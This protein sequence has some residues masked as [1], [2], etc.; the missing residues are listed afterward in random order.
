M[1]MTPPP[2]TISARQATVMFADI[3]DTTALG[4]A[5]TRGDRY[6]Q[7]LLRRLEAIVYAWRRDRRVRRTASKAAFGLTLTAGAVRARPS[8]RRWRCATRSRCNVDRALDRRS[9]SAS[10]S[11]RARSRR[12]R[13]G[14]RATTGPASWAGGTP[15]SALEDR[16]AAGLRRP[17]DLGRD[18]ERAFA[19]RPVEV[20]GAR[21]RARKHL[22]RSGRSRPASASAAASGAWRPSCS[23]T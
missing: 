10:A 15:A 23:P 6:H 1:R 14:R 3:S 22:Q 11:A 20:E 16:D 12:C 9:A 8:P 2:A 4:N 21:A 17:R 18:R 13:P 19:Y 5:S 7:W